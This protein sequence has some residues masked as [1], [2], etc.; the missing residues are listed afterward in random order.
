MLEFPCYIIA[1]GKSTRMQ[2]DKLLLPFGTSNLPDFIHR[3]LSEHFEDISI[4][5][6]SDIE[7]IKDCKAYSDIL[8]SVGPISGIHS[9]LV[10]SKSEYCF[11]IG[12]DMPFFD[13]EAITF[14]AAKLSNNEIVIFTENGKYQYLFGFYS[15]RLIPVIENILKDVDYDGHNKV[16]VS[17]KNLIEKCNSQS[18]EINKLPFFHSK[19][20]FN[21]NTVDDYMEAVKLL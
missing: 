17:M 1:G 5:N 21:V 8:K 7:Y 6:N 18:Y 11:I 12:A 16:N 10:H 9:A 15:K 19:F 3:K 13:N 4:I 2:K 14:L 20:F